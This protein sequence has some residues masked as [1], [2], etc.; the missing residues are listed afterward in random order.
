MR[1]RYIPTKKFTLKGWEIPNHVK[2][3]EQDENIATRK[4]IITK[5]N[6]HLLYYPQF[7]LFCIDTQ[8]EHIAS[9]FLT[10]K[11]RSDKSPSMVERSF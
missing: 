5:P 6:Q 1:C 4:M 7:P 3:V 11:I 10:A 8:E 9:L 2:N